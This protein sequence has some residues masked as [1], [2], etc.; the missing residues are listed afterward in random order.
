MANHV[1]EKFEI[2][3]FYWDKIIRVL[4]QHKLRFYLRR[5]SLRNYLTLH[6]QYVLHSKPLGFHINGL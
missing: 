1:W 5:F 4:Q 6:L 3:A 2:T